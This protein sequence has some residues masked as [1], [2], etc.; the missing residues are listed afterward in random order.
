MH[1]FHT[2]KFI[3]WIKSFDKKI[4]AGEINKKKMENARKEWF[5]FAF[6]VELFFHAFLPPCQFFVSII[7]DFIVV[8]QPLDY[9]Q[10]FIFIYP[11]YICNHLFGKRGPGLQ[12][13][14]LVVYKPE[15]Y[16]EIIF[17]SISLFR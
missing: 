3:W 15:I 1:F 2:H 5:C 10:D 9:F 7:T 13:G 17:L 8:E 14:F 6:I 12:D 16:A 4:N 11:F